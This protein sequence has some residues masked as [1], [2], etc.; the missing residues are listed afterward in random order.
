MMKVGN[1]FDGNN[2][3]KCFQG[4]IEDYSK[5]YLGLTQEMCTL[6]APVFLISNTENYCSLC[7]MCLSLHVLPVIVMLT[8]DAHLSMLFHYRLNATSNVRFPTCA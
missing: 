4:T 5:L 7:S 8:L 6:S 1:K 2:P 3:Y